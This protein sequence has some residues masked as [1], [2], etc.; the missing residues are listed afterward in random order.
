MLWLPKYCSNTEMFVSRSV[1]TF[2][3]YIRKQYFSLKAYSLIVTIC[4]GISMRLFDV[5]SNEFC[6]DLIC[7]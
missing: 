2:D 6:I 5:T 4:T 3:A 1:Y 7:F